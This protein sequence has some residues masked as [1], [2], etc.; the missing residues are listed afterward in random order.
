[1]ARRRFIMGTR[2]VY[3]WTDMMVDMGLDNI[4]SN[5]SEPRHAR[6]FNA[7]IE[8]CG[9]RHPDNTISGE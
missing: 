4:V 6:I 2:C 7:W 1:M 9:V 5:D 8:G 3:N